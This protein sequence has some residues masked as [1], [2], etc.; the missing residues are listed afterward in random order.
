[1]VNGRSGA[2]GQREGGPDGWVRA[3]PGRRDARPAAQVPPLLAAHSQFC[4]PFTFCSPG[5]RANGR[6]AVAL[7]PLRWRTVTAWWE[8]K[9]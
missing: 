3:G 4:Q 5:F 8:M 1:M 2:S 7:P 6:T 9:P